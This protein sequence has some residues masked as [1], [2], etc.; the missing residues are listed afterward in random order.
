MRTVNILTAI[1]K[2]LMA[3]CESSPTVQMLAT[4]MSEIV[5]TLSPKIQ[6]SFKN[7]TKK[8][9]EV[10]ISSSEITSTINRLQ[11]NSDELKELFINYHS[12][13]LQ[14][15]KETLNNTEL[16]NNK[17]DATQDQMTAMQIQMKQMQ[18]Q[19]ANISNQLKA[20][21]CSEENIEKSQTLLLEEVNS[22]KEE[23]NSVQNLNN[24]DSIIITALLNKLKNYKQNDYADIKLIHK[25]LKK[26]HDNPEISYLLGQVFYSEIRLQDALIYYKEAYAGD[27]QN[28]KYCSAVANVYFYLGEYKMSRKYYKKAIG[29]CEK[30]TPQPTPQTGEYYSFLSI[31][32]YELRNYDDYITYNQKSLEHNKKYFGEDSINVA[33]SLM[34]MANALDAQ[35]KFKEAIKLNKQNINTIKKK[36]H[37]NHPIIAELLINQGIIYTRVGEKLTAERHFKK[38]KK[39]ILK[40]YNESD[41]I[42]GKLYENLASLYLDSSTLKLAN[43]FS[44][45]AL[46][47]K[48]KNYGKKHPIFAKSLLSRSQVL[49]LMDEPAKALICLTKAE[50]IMINSFGINYP[51]KHIVMLFKEM[52]AISLKNKKDI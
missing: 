9:I 41:P 15:G 32:A 4:L 22:K 29:I 50:H 3:G 19:L 30:L 48:M 5:P 35:G 43:K 47:N 49:N 51:D 18:E 17:A 20:Q 14:I 27:K 45:K 1:L 23:I 13:L 16:L 52:I 25:S 2:A 8:E 40:Y 42:M 26:Y 28:D 31:I 46:Y 7:L 44:K 11:I 36:Y 38:A 6:E 37:A 24:D 10:A 12:E 21:G 33:G 39:I 34:E